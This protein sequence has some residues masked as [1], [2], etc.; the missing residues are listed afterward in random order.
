MKITDWI[1]AICTVVTTM[2][3][4]AAFIHEI[5]HQDR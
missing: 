2:V 4:L 3:S 5:T 1:Q